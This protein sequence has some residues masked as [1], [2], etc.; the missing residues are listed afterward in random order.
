MPRR[1]QRAQIDA[2]MFESRKSKGVSYDIYFPG[3]EQRVAVLAEKLTHWEVKKLLFEA[4]KVSPTL[5]G[6]DGKVVRAGGRLF[7]FR[8][9]RY[10]PIEGECRP[11]ECP[12][13]WVMAFELD[14]E[15]KVDPL[16][17]LLEVQF[18]RNQTGTKAVTL[19]VSLAGKRG[20][21]HAVW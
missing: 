5:L 10:T 20:G 11:E 12:N 19:A 9:G 8:A 17:A 1:K 14:G 18:Q 21:K 4:T 6:L 16:G 13:F 3:S 7:R 2:V 15:R